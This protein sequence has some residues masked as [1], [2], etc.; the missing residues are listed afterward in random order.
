MSRSKTS[1]SAKVTILCRNKTKVHGIK[2][3]GNQV[4]R[5]FLLWVSALRVHQQEVLLLFIVI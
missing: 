5:S 3:S 4:A 2:K 1:R